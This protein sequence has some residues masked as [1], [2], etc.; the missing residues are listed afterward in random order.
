LKT[1]GKNCVLSCDK[2]HVHKARRFVR[3]LLSN[4]YVKCSQ[5]NVRTDYLTFIAHTE[6][7]AINLKF[8]S[9]NEFKKIID[10]QDEKI[11]SLKKELE[12]LKEARNEEKKK[13]DALKKEQLKTKIA[14]DPEMKKIREEMLKNILDVHAK[15][16]FQKAIIE[17]KYIDFTHMALNGYPILE[18]ISPPN[19]YWTALHYTMYY[20][21]L[22]MAEFCISTLEKEGILDKA[23][24]IFSSDGRC[25]ILC[26]LTNSM[27]LEQKK[28][29]LSEI[30]INHPKIKISDYAKVEIKKRGM[31]NLL[32]IYCGIDI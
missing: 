27:T 15:S 7:C 20:G 10:D 13:Q 14:N 31:A 1:Q 4:L 11:N 9:R 26:L 12:T 30:L 19:Y 2:I 8:F 24:V 17:G 16:K 29:F 28:S 21:Q 23:M 6:T 25:P 22:D 32:K 18:E 5:C 3:N